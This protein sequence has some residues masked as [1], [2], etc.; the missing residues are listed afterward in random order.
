MT[1]EE[2]QKIRHFLKM[3]CRRRKARKGMGALAK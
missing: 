2:A 3:A 1:Y